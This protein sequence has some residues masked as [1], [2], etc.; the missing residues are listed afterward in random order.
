MN[1]LKADNQEKNREITKDKYQN[2]REEEEKKNR[3]LQEEVKMEI[4]KMCENIEQQQQHLEFEEERNKDPNLFKMQK[5]M[6]QNVRQDHSKLKTDITVAQNRIEDLNQREKM[7]I[8]SIQDVLTDKRKVD[9]LHT[10]LTNKIEGKNQD[11]DSAKQK[12]KDE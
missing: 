9:K 11:S 10:E 5:Q 3:K 8:D 6:H 1:N 12:E 2:K 4:D 7:L